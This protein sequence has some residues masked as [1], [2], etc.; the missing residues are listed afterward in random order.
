MPSSLRRT[1]EDFWLCAQSHPPLLQF[2]ALHVAAFTLPAFPKLVCYL[3]PSPEMT[4][5]HGAPSPCCGHTVLTTFESML[6]FVLCV[7]A[8]LP[9][10]Y[11]SLEDA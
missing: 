10:F 11:L 3:V 7:D 5:L 4:P 8:E 1:K 9:A 6:L 2:A